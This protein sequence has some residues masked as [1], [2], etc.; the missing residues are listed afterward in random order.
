MRLEDSWNDR[1][2][3]R[4]RWG[5]RQAGGFFFRMGCSPFGLIRAVGR[6]A[7]ARVR[8]GHAARSLVDPGAVLKL[9]VPRPLSMRRRMRE[10]SESLRFCA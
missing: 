1:K 6:G 8:S 3:G 10:G 7:S 9:S 4:C 5:S 2:V